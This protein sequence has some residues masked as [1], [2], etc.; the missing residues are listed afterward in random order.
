MSKPTPQPS[1]APIIDPKDAF[2]QFLDSVARF[3]FWAGTVATLISLG[4]LIYTFQTFMS[5]GA[6][7]NQ[8]LALSNIGLFKNILL[9]G[10]LALSVGATFTFWGEEVL[11]FLQL[12]GAGALFFA[13]IYLPMVLAVGQT[14]TPVSSEALAAMQFAG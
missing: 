4:F 3:L 10:V 11:G 2:V 1:P 13:P 7:L 8:D 12:L 5:G 9:A 14:P 6:G